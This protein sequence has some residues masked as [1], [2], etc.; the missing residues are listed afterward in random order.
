METGTSVIGTERIIIITLAN[1]MMTENQLSGG[2]RVFVEL[3]KKLNPNNFVV[4]VVTTEVGEKLWKPANPSQLIILPSTKLESLM[5][6]AAVPIVYSIRSLT[7]FIR[8]YR[9]VSR[10]ASA[11]LYSSSDF[12]PDTI[13]A[14]MIKLLKKN[15]KWISRVYHMIPSPSRRKGNLIL[16]I[17]S[18]A[19]QRMSISLMKKKSDLI[20]GLN[21]DVQAD[22]ATLGVPSSRL[23]ISGAGI[24]IDLINS[25]DPRPEQYDGVF[26]GRI[27]PSKGIF[28]ALDV[29]KSV[30]N[31]RRSARLAIIGGGDNDLIALLRKRILEYDLVENVDYLGFIESDRVVYSIMKSAKLFIFADHEAGWSLAACEAMACGLPVVG[32]E[33]QIFG[34]V[35]KKGFVTVP[36]FDTHKFASQVLL[37]MNDEKWRMKLQEEAHEQARLFDWKQVADDFATLTFL[38]FG[39]DTSSPS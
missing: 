12:F 38:C 8:T 33:L 20:I 6:L 17:L 4:K 19:S 7:A 21:E 15:V 25:V 16:N 37:L 2:D 29:W 24:D 22:L 39:K 14:F 10:D 5:G 18:F 9:L 34:S 27:H 11:I 32:Y 35:F 1:T 36:L 31:V 13:P 3:S 26:L 28:D 30:V 23:A